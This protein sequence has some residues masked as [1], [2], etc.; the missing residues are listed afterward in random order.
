[1]QDLKF[2]IHITPN[3]VDEWKQELSEITAKIEQLVK[4]REKLQARINAIPLFLE[5]F[6]QESLFETKRDISVHEDMKQSV[7]SN[8]KS[9]LSELTP[10]N[11]IRHVLNDANVN[12][13]KDE[14]RERLRLANYDMKRF[15]HDGGYFHTIISRMERAGEIEVKNGK[16][17][18]VR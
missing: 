17:S 1:M 13:S 16:I 6:K 8:G 4:Q 5:D 18:L 3:K 14:V 9:S 2:Q 15:R 12:L 11:A 10:P 7:Q